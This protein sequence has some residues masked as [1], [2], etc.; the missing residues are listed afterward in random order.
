VLVVEFVYAWREDSERESRKQKAESSE[1][2]GFRR[3]GSGFRYYLG[4]EI[5]SPR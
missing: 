1:L 5:S 2:R 4:G 3:Q